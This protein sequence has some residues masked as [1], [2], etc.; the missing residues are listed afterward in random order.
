MTVI[1]IL[2]FCT[3]FTDFKTGDKRHDCAFISRLNQLPDVM[4][5]WR[6]SSWIVTGPSMVILTVC[7]IIRIRE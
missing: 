1:C 2:V 3:T 5:Q 7:G 6:M 4:N